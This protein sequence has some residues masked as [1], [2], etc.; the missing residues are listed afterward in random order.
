[1]IRRPRKQE[2]ITLA[3]FDLHMP[4]NLQQCHNWISRNKTFLFVIIFKNVAVIRQDFARN[5]FE[6]KTLSRS[7]STRVSFNF[8]SEHRAQTHDFPPFQPKVGLR[9]EQ[10]NCRVGIWS[11]KEAKRYLRKHSTI[12]MKI[13]HLTNWQ[14]ISFHTTWATV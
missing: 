2:N 6:E 13:F 10:L 3:L 12:L 7:L 8:K 4:Y 9:L 14:V 11:S 5:I 1:M